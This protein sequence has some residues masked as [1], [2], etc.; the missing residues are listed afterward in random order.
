[1]AVVADPKVT[2]AAQRGRDPVRKQLRG[3]SL[4]LMGRFLSRGINFFSQLLIVRTLTTGDYGAFAY[5]LAVVAFWDSLSSLGLNKAITRFVPIYHE[6]GQRGEVLG[7]ILLTSGAIVL[8]SLVAVGLVQL[9]PDLV[10]RLVSERGPIDLLLVLIFL[11]PVQAVD[12]LLLGL[13]ACFARPKAI[14]FRKHFLA[15][16]LKLSVVVLLVLMHA[17]VH[18][19]ARGYVLASAIG[20]AIYVLLF[21]RLFR[22]EGIAQDLSR[23]DIRIPVREMFAYTLP[24][25][26]SSMVPVVIHSTATMILGYFHPASEVARYRAILPAAQLNNIVLASFGTLF[27]PTAARLFAR[28]DGTGVRS[29]YWRTAVWMAVLSFPV[30]ALT[31]SLAKSLTVTL[32]GERYADSWMI[33]QW[34]SGAYYF[35]TALGNNGLTLKV[36]GRFRYVVIINVLAMAVSV[37]LTFL[38]VPRYGAI[39]TGL[40]TALAITLHNFMKQAGLRAAGIGV[41]ERRTWPVYAAIIGGATGLFLLQLVVNNFF[42]LLPAAL[43]VSILVLGFTKHELALEDTFPELLRLPVIGS[44]LRAGTSKHFSR[45][46]R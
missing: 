3:S 34:V 36:L 39:G 30:F 12:L 28:G 16:V 26:S 6:R 29:L 25:L 35:S 2:L 18:F 44:L 46:S 31:F 45:R 17:D 19:L 22:Q 11:V 10:S 13:F 8:T 20:V 27:T 32:Y 42:F 21:V 5:G 15:P 37:A 24:L 4:L 7:A 14:F 23:S 40:A 33:L 1:M 43:V 41:F 38:L 9:A